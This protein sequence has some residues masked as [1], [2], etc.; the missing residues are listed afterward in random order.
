[1][2]PDASV[3]PE[4]VLIAPSP[5]TNPRTKVTQPSL[6][7]SWLAAL[8]D[9]P[10]PVSS[11][12]KVKEA[13]LDPAALAQEFGT[14]E[15]L[16][17][18]ANAF[19]SWMEGRT[20]KPTSRLPPSCL[21]HARCKVLAV[22]STM[23]TPEDVSW[24]IDLVYDSMWNLLT[25]LWQWNEG[26]RPNGAEPIKRV[27]MT[28]LATGNGGIGFDKCVRQMFLAALNF[29]RGWGDHP[30]WGGLMDRC[31]EMD[32]TRVFGAILVK[33]C[34]VRRLVILLEMLLEFEGAVR[35]LERTNES[36]CHLKGCAQ[37]KIWTF[38]QQTGFGPERIS[39]EC[40]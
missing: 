5:R 27:L 26:E 33:Y 8:K 18:P 4:F 14:F 39:R 10:E 11:R 35:L 16:V 36:L 40:K 7:D 23:R 28:D 29:A 6:C 25:A 12:F 19:G 38:S 24:H 3:L 15:C 9:L 13:K 21:V 2:E 31:R 20:Q 17:S 37:F 1:M 22:V 34:K 30:R 32:R